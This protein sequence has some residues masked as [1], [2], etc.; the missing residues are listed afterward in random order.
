MRSLKG[1]DRRQSS[2][3]SAYRRLT[4]TT[5]CRSAL[6]ATSMD[7][8][9]TSVRGRKGWVERR[10]ASCS[11][12]GFRWAVPSTQPAADLEAHRMMLA[13]GSLV[14]RA[15]VA[16]GDDEL[17][18]VDRD[19]QPGVSV[20]GLGAAWKH[21]Q[22][23]ARLQDVGHALVA[24]TDRCDQDHF[25]QVQSNWLQVLRIGGASDR[26]HRTA[27]ET[28]PTPVPWEAPLARSAALP[29]T[30]GHGS[31]HS[32]LSDSRGR[33]LRRGF[34]GGDR[35]RTGRRR[36]TRPT[37]TDR[38]SSR[39]CADARATSRFF[40]FTSWGLAS[41]EVD[42]TRLT[43]RS[44]S[45]STAIARRRFGFQL[46]DDEDLPVRRG[47]LDLLRDAMTHGLVVR[48][49]YLQRVNPPTLSNCFVI[50]IE[51]APPASTAPL[52]SA[53]V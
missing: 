41:E 7:D 14:G 43:P 42:Q 22:I 21:G 28:H 15:D 49:E 8:R 30:S 50:R 27:H 48:P 36:R 34:S 11:P 45:D 46:R 24:G 12:P 33:I 35:W 16:R 52:A 39:S 10:T 9:V 18:L 3:G 29:G 2:R 20:P 31:R 32:G 6:S 1:P 40:E 25:F 47:M 44:S 51:L 23:A 37:L 38:T 26:R 19:S 4:I 5:S 17:E 53:S 13:L